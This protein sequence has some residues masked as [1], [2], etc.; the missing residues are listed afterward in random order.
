MALL[1]RKS[2]PQ[3]FIDSN[4]HSFPRQLRYAV[5]LYSE[6]LLGSVL[7]IDGFKWIEVYFNGFIENC[8]VLRQVIRETISSCADLLAY[9]HKSLQVTVTLPCHQDHFIAASS[10]HGVIL[11]YDQGRHIAKC[12]EDE[13]I[14]P[15]VVTEKRQVCWLNGK[16]YIIIKYMCMHTLL[17]YSI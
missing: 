4:S 12:S 11:K 8:P 7:L 16:L 3:F 1:N 10:F 15:F 14:P 5:R 13:D 17:S 2:R 9:D 6:D